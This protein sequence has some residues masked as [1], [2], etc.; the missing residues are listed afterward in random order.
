MT[1]LHPLR[2]ALSTLL[3]LVLMTSTAASA[4][5]RAKLRAFLEITGFDVAI[6]SLQQGAKAGPGLAGEAPDQF[7]SEWVRLATEIFD[8]DE[9]V[10]RALDMMEAIMPEDLV[11]HGA[12]FYAS[13][14]GQRL[15][16]VENES[17]LVDD[18]IKYPEAEA[19]VTAL[20]DD[21]SPRLQMFRDMS[22]AI[23]GIDNSVR[24]VIEIQVRYFMAAMAAGSIEGDLSEEDLRGMLASQ[25]DDIRQNVELYSM[26]GSAYTYRDL[27]DEDLAEYVNALQDPK[28]RQVYEILNA[29]QFEVMAE[30]YERLAA[31]L[32]GLAP[33]QD[34]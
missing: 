29:I 11:D 6:E 10:N 12:A 31:A 2:F 23:G 24:S 21:N 30:R 9:M 34:I 26:L 28:M 4:T 32:A 33:Q 3:A 17:Q 13:D 1:I 22:D 19:I 18:D 15:V 20:V 16:A 25:A 5:E 8:P 7:G 27:S 14:L